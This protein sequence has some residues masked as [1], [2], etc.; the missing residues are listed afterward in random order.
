M[1]KK[2]KK[3]KAPVFS[4]I[5]DSKINGYAIGISFLV[6]STFLL[7]NNSYFH[8][9]ILTYFIGAVF[10]IIGVAGIGTELD[11]SKKFKG[12]GNLVIGLLCLGIW[13]ATVILFNN[14]PVANSIS[15][16]A[17]IIGAYGFVR[18]L[19]ELLYSVLIEAI[20]SERSFSKIAKAFFVLITQLC[21][22]T[23]T[24]LNILK[25]FKIV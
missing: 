15:M 22:L 21:G 17:L 20:N 11:K 2:D 16:P 3:E 23:L 8:W 13:I 1:A 19:L 6:I 12:I 5:I 7:I 10:G 25:I 4:E 9:T 14:N 18:G 24:I